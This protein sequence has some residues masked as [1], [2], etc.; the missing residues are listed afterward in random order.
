[1]KSKYVGSV[2]WKF[3]HKMLIFDEVR[4]QFMS[5]TFFRRNR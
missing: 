3:G 1:M 5:V 4:Q 2:C